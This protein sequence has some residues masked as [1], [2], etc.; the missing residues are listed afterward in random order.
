MRGISD[1]LPQVLL[2]TKSPLAAMLLTLSAILLPLVR[3][4]VLVALML[5]RATLPNESE[6]GAR[7]AL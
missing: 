4:T 6:V 7:V 2:W 5:P 3:V 1:E